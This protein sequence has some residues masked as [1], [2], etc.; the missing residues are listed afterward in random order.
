MTPRRRDGAVEQQRLFESGP[1]S[2]TSHATVMEP[3]PAMSREI[4]QAR[5]DLET[6]TNAPGANATLETVSAMGRPD[7]A[8]PDDGPEAVGS[9]AFE[10]LAGDLVHAVE[11]S[12]EADRVAVLGSILAIFGVLAGRSKTLYQGGPQGCNLNVALV[13][14]SSTARK[15]TSFSVARAAF[16]A[17]VPAWEDI[18]VPGLG[19][20]EGLIGHLKRIEGKDNRALVLETELGRLLKVMSR[21]GST[22]GPVIRDSWDGVPLGRVLAREESRVLSHHVGCLAHVTPT[23]LRG[24]LTDVDRANGFGN[25]FIWLHVRRRRLLPFP[26]PPGPLFAPFAAA[27]GSAIDEA[28]FPGSVTFTAAAAEGWEEYYVREALRPRFGITGALTAR[29]DAQVARVALVFAL[30]DRSPAIHIAHLR[31]AIALIEYAERSVTFIFGSSVGNRVADLVLRTLADGPAPTMELR[32]EAGV[33]DGVRMGAALD[34]LI[35]LGLVAM[36]KGPS[37]PNGGRPPDVY[38]LTER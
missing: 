13:G 12:T 30:L 2:R 34:L 14:D 16:D 36:E 15:G 9:E 21:E 7:R 25:R 8:Q 11:E 17:A 6:P 20:G 22:L 19:S 10:G 28:Q 18:V 26:Q 24:E 27:L 33:S 31:A 4:D 29:R 35:G 37:G 23:E 1:V 3:D 5:D 38:R 32:K